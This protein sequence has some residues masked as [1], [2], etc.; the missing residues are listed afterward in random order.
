M[1]TNKSRLHVVIMMLC[2]QR[3]V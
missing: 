3:K 1:T 2:C